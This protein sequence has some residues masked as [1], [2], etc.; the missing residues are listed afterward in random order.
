MQHKT[1]ALL[2]PTTYSHADMPNKRR[3][4]HVNRQRKITNDDS[5]EPQNKDLKK[6]KLEDDYDNESIAGKVMIA[7]DESQEPNNDVGKKEED[8]S[9]IDN[10]VSQLVEK[11]FS[12]ENKKKEINNGAMESCE[13]LSDDNVDEFVCSKE[14]TR[15]GSVV[16]TPNRMLRGVGRSDSLLNNSN[17]KNQS[18]D[19]TTTSKS[20]KGKDTEQLFQT[21]W[22]CFECKE[23]ECMMNEDADEL[24]ICDGLCQRLFHYP[25]AGLQ[26]LPSP[27]EDFICNDCSNQRYVCSFCQS[28]GTGD[29]AVFKCS[30]NT[31]GLF[32]HERCLQMQ[33]VDVKIIE[34]NTTTQT[35]TLSNAE[36]CSTT[37]DTEEGNSNDFACGMDNSYKC[38]FVCPAH[39]CWTCNQKDLKEREKNIDESKSDVEVST[40]SMTLSSTGIPMT[41]TKDSQKISHSK[42]T[43]KLS[44]RAKRKTGSFEPK[45]NGILMVGGM[46]IL[47]SVHFLWWKCISDC[48]LSLDLRWNINLT[49]QLLPFHVSLSL[50]N[51]II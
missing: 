12:D 48:E 41:Q 28:Y 10:N 25:C 9:V 6:P 17:K 34:T 18:T 42:K 46:S 19:K 44:K 7:C 32:F 16:A 15:D 51:I 47:C 20:K 43:P 8:A 1:I 31:C 40:G 30:K 36:A 27:D 24:L 37:E 29:E 39:A 3:K 49:N 2:D 5:E 38:V 26:K 45:P 13:V 33:N 23:A 50:F 4:L 11:D 22:I 35:T 21:T 14:E